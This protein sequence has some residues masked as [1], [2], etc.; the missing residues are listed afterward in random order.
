MI[1]RPPRSTRTVT[2]FP[3]T[4]LFRSLDTL[5]AHPRFANPKIRWTFAL[6]GKDCVPEVTRSRT[7]D[8][9]PVGLA[10]R[11][12]FTCG[13]KYEL[14]VRTWAEVLSEANQRL[15]FLRTA[16]DEAPTTS[17][18][19]EQLHRLHGDVLPSLEDV[20]VDTTA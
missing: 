5:G 11:G 3:Y 4:T 13:S 14:W 12:T 17:A 15:E 16:M 18:E 8:G 9:R 20:G 1:L 19:F 7:Q 2:L 6:V 10:S